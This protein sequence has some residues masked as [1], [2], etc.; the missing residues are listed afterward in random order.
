MAA[1]RRRRRALTVT[2]VVVLL[3][4][5]ALLGGYWWQRP[6]LL[7]GTGYAAHNECAVRLL[8]GR[9]DPDADLPPNPLVPHLRS[10]S[11]EGADGATGVESTVRGMA[12][13]RAWYSEGYGCTI[14]DEPP[15]RQDLEEVTRGHRW[16]EGP[17]VQAEDPE[18]QAALARAYGEDLTTSEQAELGTRA[19]VVMHDGEIIAERYAEGFDPAT[20]QLGWS[21]AKSVA[22]LL[23]GIMVDDGGVAISDDRLR[24][25]W[26]DKRESITIDQ[27]MRMTSGLEWD[28]T[29]ALG[30]PIT[31]MLYLEPDMP[32]YVASQEL[33]HEPG[34]YQQ[35][36]SGSTTLLCQTLFER[37]GVPAD[38]R[39]DLPRDL[40]FRALGL[41]TAVWETD[42]RGNP[43]CSSYLWAGARD[44]AAIG[45]FAL[46]QGEWEGA[47]LLPEDWM[48]EST[49][50]HEVEETEEEGY[51]AGWWV[52]QEADGSIVSPLLPADAYQARG[53][54]GQRL[55]VVPSADLVVVR[56]GFTP[57]LEDVG[58][59]RLVADLVDALP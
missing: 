44:W 57:E 1:S 36:S 13:Q 18:V 23:V 58:T 47:E 6:L 42:A 9:D 15:V 7:T 17:V 45:Q 12:G 16:T 52:N 40:L 11:I 46:Q 55:V 30:T 50:Q 54:D 5:A 38:E 34:T 56:L 24:P 4:A 53:H 51:A 41:T 14:G 48:A 33:A 8:A 35:Y 3:V 22:N 37:A 31:R 28:E 25:E 43:V 20:P 59:D 19:V 2:L 32:A 10:S 29:Y 49:T 26:T 27:L 21:M 39:G